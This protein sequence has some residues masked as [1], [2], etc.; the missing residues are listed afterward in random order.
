MQLRLE[1]FNFSTSHTLEELLRETLDRGSELTGSPIGYYHFV[2]EDQMTISLQSW[3]TRTLREFCKVQGLDTHYPV[4]EAGV[5][6]DCIRQRAPVIHNDYAALPH[7]RGLPEGHSPIIRDLA[8][9]VL[10]NDRVVARNNF[11]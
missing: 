6:V 4:N 7:K 9:P 1:L 2:N 3:S 11:V 5:W 10:K 8:V